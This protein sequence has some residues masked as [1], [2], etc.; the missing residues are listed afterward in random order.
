MNIAKNIIKKHQK[1]VDHYLECA[2][3]GICVTCNTKLE[4]KTIIKSY[5][6]TSFWLFKNL[7]KY[8]HIIIICPNGH[9]L[10]HPNHLDERN[11]LNCSEYKN[12]INKDIKRARDEYLYNPYDD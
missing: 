7:I 4:L 9:K 11:D 12:I 5:V 1:E 3:A 8:K 6:N 10:I 2:T